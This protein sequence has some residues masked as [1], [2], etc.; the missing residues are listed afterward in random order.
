M[1]ENERKWKKM[2]KKLKKI[3]ENIVLLISWVPDII[4]KCF[5]TPDG[6]IG[7]TLQLKYVPAF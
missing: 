2:K 4:K 3:K 6:P 1:K 7:P 5:C